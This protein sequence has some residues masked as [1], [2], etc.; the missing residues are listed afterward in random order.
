MEEIDGR[1]IILILF[2]VISAIKWFIEKFKGQDGSPHEVSES[3]E[4]IYENFRE[5]IRDRQTTVQ[6]EQ[7]ANSPPPLPQTPAPVAQKVQTLSP[8]ATQFSLLQ[9]PKKPTLTAEEKAAAARFQQLTKRKRRRRSSR[10]TSVRSLLSSPQSAQQAII[11]MEIL[12]KPKS[13][14]DT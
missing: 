3:L 11:L 9:R 12:G 10:Q 6:Q 13:L 8:Q 1:I 2:V 7:P 14:Q 4:D 5:E